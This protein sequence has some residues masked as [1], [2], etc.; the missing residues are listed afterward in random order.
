MARGDPIFMRVDLSLWWS[1]K[2]RKLSCA[3]K[4]IYLTIL[5]LAV[6][7][8]STVLSTDV[9]AKA[10]ADR[11][12]DGDG[13][14]PA[15]IEALLKLG[16]LRRLPDGRLHVPDV[17]RNNFKIPG[18]HILP[19]DERGPSDRVEGEP[20][21]SPY[22]TR[23]GQ[24]REEDTT[25]TKQREGGC[26]PATAPNQ[27]PIPDDHGRGTPNLPLQIPRSPPP[28]SEEEPNEQQVSAIE[29]KVRDWRTAELVRFA[30]TG[31]KNGSVTNTLTEAIK[32]VP[33]DRLRGICIFLIAKSHLNRWAGGKLAASVTQ[34]CREAMEDP[35]A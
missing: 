24:E 4:L 20:A 17:R 5:A 21:S 6:E 27:G 22:P 12:G 28:S 26:W 10:I 35:A 25:D 29:E 3:A 23:K 1:V 8:R 16:L 18:W 7:G 34:R 31:N 14:T 30:A 19:E 9:D 13:E 32:A 2:F 15:T 33:S 11:A